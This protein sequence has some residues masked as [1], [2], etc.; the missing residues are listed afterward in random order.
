MWLGVK[1]AVVIIS[2]DSVNNTVHNETEKILNSINIVRAFSHEVGPGIV[3]EQGIQVVT[4]NKITGL[5]IQE[6]YKTF[7]FGKTRAVE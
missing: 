5:F 2:I 3:R 7:I 6:W 4:V 1:K